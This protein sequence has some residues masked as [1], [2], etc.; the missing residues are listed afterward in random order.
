MKEN[1]IKE[2]LM[3]FVNSVIVNPSFD[4][5][6]KETLT[7]NKSKFGSECLVPDKFIETL[8]VDCKVMELLM[9]KKTRKY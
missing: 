7:T 9:E 2:N 8:A 4:S 6:T 3:V 5:Q 1:T